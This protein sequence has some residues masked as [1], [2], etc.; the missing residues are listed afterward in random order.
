[1]VF[2]EML[3]EAWVSLE[4][5]REPQG[6]ARVASAKSGLSYSCEWHVRIPVELLP[7]NR[8]VCRVQ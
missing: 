3:R 1:M 6:P 8:A 2:L 4:L 7:V 5:R